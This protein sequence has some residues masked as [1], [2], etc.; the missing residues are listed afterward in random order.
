MEKRAGDTVLN[1]RRLT[2]LLRADSDAGHSMRKAV[3]RISGGHFLICNGLVCLAVD[4]VAAKWK[5]APSER[6]PDYDARITVPWLRGGDTYRRSRPEA[7]G[8]DT[9]FRRPE[10]SGTDGH[11]INPPPARGEDDAE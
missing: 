3:S 9:D 2:T 11:P 6:Y 8:N 7:S 4:A 10:L 5:P 1:N